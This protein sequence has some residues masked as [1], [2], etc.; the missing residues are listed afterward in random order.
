MKKILLSLALIS[1]FAFSQDECK[2]I[3]I[4]DNAVTITSFEDTYKHKHEDTIETVHFE[5]I[6][7]FGITYQRIYFY[8]KGATGDWKHIVECDKGSY[9]NR[10]KVYQLFKKEF[11][12]FKNAKY[13]G[14]K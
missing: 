6:S 7:E 8:I 9:E 10:K 3:L 12:E 4:A 14:D 2:E 5:D 11:L 1:T 13:K